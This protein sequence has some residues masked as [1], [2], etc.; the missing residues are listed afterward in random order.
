MSKENSFKKGLNVS[1]SEMNQNVDHVPTTSEKN[2]NTYYDFE[3]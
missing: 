2:H 3:I 1:T